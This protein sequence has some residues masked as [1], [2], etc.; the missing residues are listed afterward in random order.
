MG[1][2]GAFLHKARFKYSIHQ[3]EN[4]TG[5]LVEL[6]SILNKP[7]SSVNT[8]TS[9]ADILISAGVVTI[10]PFANPDVMFSN[11]KAFDAPQV[12]ML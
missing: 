6:T 10:S 8:R 2:V 4:F 1:L 12:T 3:S 9:F 7:L 5:L 11:L